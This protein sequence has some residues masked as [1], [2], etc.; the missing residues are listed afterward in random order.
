MT[1]D[2]AAIPE[3]CT[4]L[5]KVH[6]ARHIN[7]PSRRIERTNLAASHPSAPIAFTAKA[8]GV[9]TL[10]LATFPHPTILGLRGAVSTP[11]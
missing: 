5:S 4:E 6:Q 8:G 1:M 3:S 7:S 9:R 2:N 10:G 11:S